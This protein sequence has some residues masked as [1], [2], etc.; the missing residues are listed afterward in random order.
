MKLEKGESKFGE[1][2]EVRPVARYRAPPSRARHHLARGFTT[3]T[4][5]TV[6]AIEPRTI[7]EIAIFFW[8]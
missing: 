2:G 5:T 8:C 7:V 3:S 1:G 4:T 6:E